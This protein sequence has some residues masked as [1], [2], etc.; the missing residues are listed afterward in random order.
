MNKLHPPY[1]TITH[2]MRGFFAV[3]MT[4]SD[5]GDGSSEGFYEPFN[6]GFESYKT[7]E[8]A[9]PEARSWAFAEECEL[10][11]KHLTMVK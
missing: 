9:I 5:D 11:V 2:G 10:R 6:T 8:D 1:V 7:Y 4:W 3:L